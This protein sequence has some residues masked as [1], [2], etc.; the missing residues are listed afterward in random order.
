MDLKVPRPV[1]PVDETVIDKKTTSVTVEREW[2]IKQPAGNTGYDVEYRIKDDELQVITEITNMSRVIPDLKP[3]DEV[4]WRVRARKA[5]EVLD[6][7]DYFNFSIE[8]SNFIFL[9]G[10]EAFDVN[11]WPNPMPVGGGELNIEV[12]G[13]LKHAVLRIYTINGQML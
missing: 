12:P 10:A 6:W 9:P 2:D 11:I 4:R 3:G 7:S 8:E 5:T 1:Y 13:T